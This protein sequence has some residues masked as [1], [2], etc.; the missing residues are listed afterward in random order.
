MILPGSTIGVLGGGQL[1]RMLILAGSPLGFKFHVYCPEEDSVAGEIATTFTKAKYEDLNALEAFAQSVDCIT[2]EFENIPFETLKILNQFKPIYPNANVLHICQNREREKNFLKS[3]NFPCARFES[4]SSPT[5]LEKAIKNIGAP[6]VIKTASFG[7][8]GKGQIKINSLEEIDSYNDLWEKL[9]LSKKVV[10]EEWIQHIGEFSI[11]CA[12]KSNG[13]ISSFPMS[14]NHHINHILYSSTAPT[15]IDTKIEKEGC[16][17][18]KSIAEKLNVVGLISIE[19][20]LNKDNKLIVNEMAPRPHNSGH[21]TIDACFTSQ[22]EQHIRAITELPFGST[23]IHTPAVMINLLGDLWNKGI[24]SW[25]SILKD[26]R[27]KLHLYNKKIARPG[28]KMGHF[29]LLD[30]NLGIA[31]K[32]S[33]KLFLSLKE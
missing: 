1:G 20:F 3:N 21:Y 29:T 5:D 11:I 13:E 23:K 6:C 7:Y 17:L 33:E 12:R 14:K 2:F 30:S 25:E 22:F 18:G 8:D 9:K 28:R 16:Y 26:S 19:F 32:D 24:P 10:V 4:A 31:Q 15:E 27:T